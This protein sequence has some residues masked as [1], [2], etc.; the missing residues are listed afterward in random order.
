MYQN[1]CAYIPFLARQFTQSAWVCFYILTHWR[2]EP[3]WWLLP[4]LQGTKGTEKIDWICLPR[5][6]ASCFADCRQVVVYLLEF[7]VCL[8]E[9]LEVEFLLSRLTLRID[10]NG[11]FALCQLPRYS[12]TQ[13]PSYPVTQLLSQLLGSAWTHAP[14][15][16]PPWA[17]GL[18]TINCSHPSF[19]TTPLP[20]LHWD[21]IQP[22][23]ATPT[24]SANRSKKAYIPQVPIHLPGP[25]PAR[26]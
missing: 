7:S 16:L 4:K 12:D 13:L 25:T 18:H 15:L 8:G 20:A 9:N 1:S 11:I 21:P 2:T 14:Q 10:I 22:L 17:I 24:S 6:I 23:F 5:A 3:L 19:S 26:P